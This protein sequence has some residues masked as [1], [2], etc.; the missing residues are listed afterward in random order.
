L[1]WLRQQRLQAEQGDLTANAADVL[2]L[3]SVR[4][5]Q[6][7]WEWTRSVGDYQAAR[8]IQAGLDGLTANEDTLDLDAVR[9][10]HDQLYGR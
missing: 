10:L 4:R 9:A 7:L 8:V 5:D 6:D 3:E 1:A 2:D